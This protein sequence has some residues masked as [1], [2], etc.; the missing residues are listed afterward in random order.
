MFKTLAKSGL[1]KFWPFRP[2]R[3]AP[4]LRAAGLS[5]ATHCNDNLPGFRRP[6]AAGKRRPPGQALACHWLDRNGRLE[7]R[8]QVETGD[9]RAGR[10]SPP[11]RPQRRISHNRLRTVLSRQAEFDF[12]DRVRAFI[13]LCCAR[14]T[15]RRHSS[16]SAMPFIAI[17]NDLQYGLA[18]SGM[19][20]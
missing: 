18:I 20:P 13:P 11:P 15:R 1:A 4:G 17:A 16:L 6:A 7:C 9:D 10:R 2:R 5:N 14:V 8:W 19:F 3:V 12:H